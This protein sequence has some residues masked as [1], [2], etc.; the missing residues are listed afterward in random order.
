MAGVDAALAGFETA[1]AWPV[2]EKFAGLG[3]VADGSGEAAGL[4]A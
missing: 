1:T 2:C 3:S 4:G